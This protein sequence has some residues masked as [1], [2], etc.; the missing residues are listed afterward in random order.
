MS[1]PQV[2]ADKLVHEAQQLLKGMFGIRE[3]E[4]ND[5]VERIVECIVMAS[6]L[7]CTAIM[8]EVV[9][10][11]LPKKDDPDPDSNLLSKVS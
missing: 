6:M 7:Q 4:S 1:N 8:K 5:T 11:G 3:G 10:M 9:L 2:E